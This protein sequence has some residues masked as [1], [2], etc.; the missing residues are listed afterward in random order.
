MESQCHLDAHYARG[1]PANGRDIRRE[2][3]CDL[4]SSSCFDPFKGFSQIDLKGEIFYWPEANQAF[5]TALKKNLRSDIPVT[6]MDFDINAPEFSG[7]VAET[8]LEMLAE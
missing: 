2:A 7:K 6:E 4:R 5:I 1:K 8:L 3:E